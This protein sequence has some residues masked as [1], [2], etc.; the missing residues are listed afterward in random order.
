MRT[1]D[2]TWITWRDVQ[3]APDDGKR[4]E[5]IGGDLYVTAAPST[6][7]QSISINLASELRRLLYDPGHGLVLYAPTGVE[8]PETEEGVEPDL[9]FIS[10]ARLDIVGDDW[11]RGAPDLV[12]EILS[13]TTA[14]RDRDLKLKL[15]ERQGVP[16]YWI[17]D[18]DTDS[19]EVWRFSTGATAS[20]L[21][22]DRLPVR[23]AGRV[24]GEIDLT[25]IFPPKT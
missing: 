12:V 6:R 21:Y 1:M 20:E 23:L 5:A 16:E 14:H 4:Y 3:H 24:L 2:R 7:H 25:S 9:L 11:I 22:H 17:V 10:K 18:P 13:P 8:F 19:I 15:Y